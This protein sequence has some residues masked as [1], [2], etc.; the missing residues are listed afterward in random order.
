MNVSNQGLRDYLKQVNIYK[1]D[2]I[3]KKTD[4]IEIIIYGCTTNELDKEN[5]VDITTKHA[6]QL[7]KR[8]GI[9]LKS[10]PGYGNARIEK[11]RYET[12]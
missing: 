6:N 3:K 5:I 4:L 1:G 11:K 10:L 9:I 7:L 8:D 12:C 2:A